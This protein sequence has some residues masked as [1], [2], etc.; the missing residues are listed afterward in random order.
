MPN[1]GNWQ[2]NSFYGVR[3]YLSPIEGIGKVI[4]YI[5]SLMAKEK[6]VLRSIVTD[7]VFKLC[8]DFI[9]KRRTEEM[10]LTGCAVGIIALD[11]RI[12]YLP[13]GVNSLFFAICPG[14]NS[15]FSIFT[16]GEGKMSQ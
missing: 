12:D 11:K 16:P 3:K 7:Y 4:T 10:V 1:W 13:R 15:L 5:N 6:R 9:N 14:V 8:N 2:T